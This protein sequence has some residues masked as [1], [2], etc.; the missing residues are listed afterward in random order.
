M[1]EIGLVERGGD[2]DQTAYAVAVGPRGRGRGAMTAAADVSPLDAAQQALEHTRRQ[3]FPF[4]FERW[5]ALGFVAFLDQCGRT[6]TGFST[7][8]PGGPS[9]PSGDKAPAARS[10]P[11]WRPGSPRT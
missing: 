8:F 5:L 2:I 9:G 6:Q 3:L 10:S 7:G 11:R 1:G 4:R